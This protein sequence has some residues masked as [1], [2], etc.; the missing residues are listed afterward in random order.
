ML[1]ASDPLAL[2]LASACAARGMRIVTFGSG[3]QRS[4]CAAA[5]V[6]LTA[7]AP[8]GPNNAHVRVTL[9]A[10]GAGASLQ[11]QRLAECPVLGSEWMQSAEVEICAPGV[12]LGMNAAAAAAVGL[13]LG[14]LLNPLSLAPEPAAAQASGRGSRTVCATHMHA[15]RCTRPGVLGGPV[16][17]YRGCMRDQTSPWER[18]KAVAKLLLLRGA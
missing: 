12:H 9:E 1:N 8:C 3:P 11:Q 15:A 16:P 2:Q 13:G 4:P 10:E 6:Q 7:A 5:H 14:A 18:S 17:T